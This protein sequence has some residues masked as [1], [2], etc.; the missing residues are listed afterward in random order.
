MHL[1]SIH[2]QA[3][4]DTRRRAPLS[5]LLSEQTQSN[6]F[7][8]SNKA[9][10]ILLGRASIPPTPYTHKKNPSPPS[11]QPSNRTTVG[12]VSPQNPTEALPC[13]LETISPNTLLN[14]PTPAP[15]SIYGHIYYRVCRWLKGSFTIRSTHLIWSQQA[16]RA[17]LHG[18]D[19]A[20]CWRKGKHEQTKESV[21]THGMGW[22]GLRSDFGAT[23]GKN[24]KI[25]IGTSTILNLLVQL[26][27]KTSMRVFT[28]LLWVEE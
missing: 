14:I 28:V 1:I 18:R 15:N 9:L 5:I 2:T 22:E 24:K 8:N 26:L 16:C 23:G 7:L 20:I 13:R 6:D 11:T 3:C 19:E 25:K 17:L 27:P 10:F 4:T 21:L 12:S